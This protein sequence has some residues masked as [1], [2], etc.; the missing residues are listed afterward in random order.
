MAKKIYALIPA[1]REKDCDHAL[2]FPCRGRLP[3][4]GPRVCPLCG[5][6]QE[7]AQ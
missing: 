1:E 7:A 4:T 6:R 3:C 2:G 5:T